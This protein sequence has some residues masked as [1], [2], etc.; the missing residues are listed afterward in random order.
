MTEP[1][2]VL[3]SMRRDLEAAEYRV[4]SF[5]VGWAV[6]AMTGVIIAALAFW[7]AVNLGVVT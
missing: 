5:W 7:W 4:W 3:D 2:P 1:L 6:G